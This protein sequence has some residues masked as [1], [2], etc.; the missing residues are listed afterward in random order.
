MTTGVAVTGLGLTVPAGLDTASAWTA[1]LAGRS[2]AA[3]DPQLADAEA[4]SDLACRVPEF[5]PAE[6][7][8]AREAWRLDRFTLLALHSAQQAVTQSGLGPALWNGDRVGIVVGTAAGGTATSEEQHRRFLDQGAQGVSAL[9][10]SMALVN[11][12]AGRLAIEYGARG[13]NLVTST[14]CAS[15][16]TA[17]GTARDLILS[18]ACD[19]VLA[20]GTE[21]AITPTFVTGFARMGA[22]YKGDLPA[23]RAS[24]PFDAD[25]AGFVISEGAGMMVLESA[26]HARAR[27]A[28]VLSW[29]TGYGAAADAHHVT[30]PHPEGLGLRLAMAAA[31]AQADVS[32]SELAYINAHGTSTRFN[33]AAEA[34]AI[35]ALGAGRAVVSSVK[36]TIGHTLGAAGAVEAVCTVLALLHGQVPPTANLERLD[37]GIA[38]DV[39]AGGPRPLTGH[40]ALSNSAGFGGHNV[41]LLFTAS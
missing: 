31:C 26:A 36:G 29:L 21:A 6:L 37:P 17:L 1:L 19:V 28:T 7:V 3:H 39:A 34:R 2:L 38:L 18:G 15:G 8:G 27:S 13:P 30:T 16:A 9:M 24:R 10:H 32:P 33:D 4:A 14:A 20:G 12:V 41:C 11:M 25:R 22:L 35:N 5:N 23:D 40:H